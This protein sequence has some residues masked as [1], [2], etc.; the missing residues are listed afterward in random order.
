MTNFDLLQL[1]LHFA[2][3]LPLQGWNVAFFGAMLLVIGL[4]VVAQGVFRRPLNS[5]TDGGSTIVLC[6]A[7][8]SLG[9]GLIALGMELPGSGIAMQLAGWILALGG[10]MIPAWLWRHRAAGDAGSRLDVPSATPTERWSPW[11]APNETLIWTGA[12]EPQHFRAEAFLMFLGGAAYLLF[13][14]VVGAGLVVQFL[15]RGFHWDWLSVVVIAIEF[16]LLLFA[17]AVGLFISPWMMPRRVKDVLYAV[18]DRRAMV[19]APPP[20][21]W[22][23]I[24]LPKPA[25]ESTGGVD[26]VRAAGGP[27]EFLPEALL[28]R[29]VHAWGTGRLDL[30]FAWETV[31]SGEQ[32]RVV[33]YGFLGLSDVAAAEAAIEAAFR[34][35]SSTAS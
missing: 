35:S 7:P 26:G 18:T 14:V 23:P 16:T 4:I 21:L 32:R 5:S 27:R 2:Q 30:V 22:S 8:I 25:M 15:N 11:L 1:S 10:L 28:Q 12:P 13:A 34:R 24:P 19:L 29:R 17:S 3:D 33:E 6:G 9:Y 20:G 31:G